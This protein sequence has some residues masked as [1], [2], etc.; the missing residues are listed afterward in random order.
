M[1]CEQIIHDVW[2]YWWKIREISKEDEATILK[3]AKSRRVRDWAVFDEFLN[4]ENMIINHE[5]GFLN[6]G[7]VDSFLQI[8]LSEIMISIYL[9]T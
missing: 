4:N 9:W 8:A 7:N 5:I 3:E 6:F 2:T 1:F